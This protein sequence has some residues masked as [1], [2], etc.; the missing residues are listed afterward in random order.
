VICGVATPPERH[1]RMAA[2]AALID[3]T[4]EAATWRP[5]LPRCGLLGA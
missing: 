2:F 1:A 4:S 3:A 5:S